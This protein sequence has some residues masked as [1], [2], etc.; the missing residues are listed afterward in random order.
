MGGG[1]EKRRT[2]NNKLFINLFRGILGRGGG[3]FL[4]IK[5]I[6]RNFC[7]FIKDGKGKKRELFSLIF[8]GN[9]GKRGKRGVYSPA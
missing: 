4:Y 1:K 9:K 5:N 2:C 7:Y 3:F 8:N 6:L